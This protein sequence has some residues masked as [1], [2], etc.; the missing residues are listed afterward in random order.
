MPRPTE[1]FTPSGFDTTGDSLPVESRD[2]DAELLS[3]E[4]GDE[5]Q[6]VRLLGRGAMG[7]VYLA[8]DLA[9]HRVVAIKVL[10]RLRAVPARG[11]DDGPARAPEHRAAASVR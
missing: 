6:V 3:R 10:R 9:L 7:S 2:L 5:F 11:A 1:Q 8:R 4:L